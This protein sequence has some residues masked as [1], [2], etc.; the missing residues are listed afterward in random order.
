MVKVCIYFYAL[1]F[2][3]TL[4]DLDLRIEAKSVDIY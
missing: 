3:L 1:R 4:Y 2:F